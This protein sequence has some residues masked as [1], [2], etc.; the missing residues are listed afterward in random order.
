MVFRVH[1]W[2]INILQLKVISLNVRGIRSFNKR[3]AIFNRPFPSCLLPQFQNRSYP[4]RKNVL[5][6]IIHFDQNAFVKGRTIFDAVRTINDVLDFTKL[7]GYD[8][9]MTAIDFEKAFD[10]LNRNFPF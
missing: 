10:S 5:P 7:K 1:F 2:N 9:I 3:K 4:T 8:G 6:H